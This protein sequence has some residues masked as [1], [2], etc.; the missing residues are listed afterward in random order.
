MPL[1]L[2]V[3]LGAKRYGNKNQQKKN[4]LILDKERYRYQKFISD[5]SGQD[6][7]SHEN[8]PKEVIH[9]VRDWLRHASRRTSIPSGGS[10]WTRYQEFQS[11][12]PSIATKRQ[13]D[14]NRLIFNDY[15]ALVTGW[16]EEL[17]ILSR[18][19]FTSRRLQ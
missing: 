6:V 15:I 3:F 9:L 7:K 16:L 13:L 1:E 19:Q 2:G 12:L 17:E 11:D 18:L 4:C 14:A 5:I 10:I 8:N